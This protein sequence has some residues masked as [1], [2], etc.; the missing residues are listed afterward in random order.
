MGFDYRPNGVSASLGSAYAYMGQTYR[1]GPL[2]LVSGFAYADSSARRLRRDYTGAI[3]RLRESGANA[4]ADIG[5]LSNGN[6]DT[7][8]AAALIGANSGFYATKYDQSG[9]A[10]NSTQGTAGNQ[11]LYVASAQNSR[12]TARY[13]AASSQYLIANAV[14]DAFA[15]SDV[16]CTIMSAVKFNSLATAGEVWS[17]GS[18]AS[19]NQVMALSNT[20]TPEYNVLRRDDAATSKTFSA[21][22]PT[23]SSMAILSL[24][25]SGTVGQLFVNG[26]QIGSDT[27][28]DVGALTVNRFAF[29]ALLRSVASVFLSG[30]LPESLIHPT[31][32]S[33]ANRLLIERN[34]GAYYGVTV[35]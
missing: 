1:P 4:E 8:A 3:V 23:T 32:L 35:A 12:P 13:A 28:L 30:D 31:A 14:A 29:G 21:G 6:L 16:A 9:N 11:P 17:F 25:F 22:T 26:T 33:T 19:N 7:A 2:D 5:Y 20:T 18:S 34:M 24:V 27:N 10:R 15:G